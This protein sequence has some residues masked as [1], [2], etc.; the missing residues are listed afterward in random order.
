M[1]PHQ[2]LAVALRLVAIAW[3][4]HTLGQV[5]EALN[6]AERTDLS[7]MGLALTWA[8]IAV[9][10]LASLLMW[11]F[12]ATAAS[13]LLRDRARTVVASTIS[14]AQWATLGIALLG[15]WI[16]S[17]GI[18]DAVYWITLLKLLS[19]VDLDLMR[20]LN[21]EQRA[22]MAGTMVEVLIGGGF[23]F[24][25]RRVAGFVLRGTAAAHP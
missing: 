25:A 20:T 5:I 17:R 16:L 15:V 14:A 2:I 21:S 6:L 9:Q 7:R 12:P 24:G 19:S 23:L 10:L 13:L 1:T 18:P 3:V 22:G 8:V 4:L 11:I